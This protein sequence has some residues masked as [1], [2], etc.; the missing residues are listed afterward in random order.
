MRV[1]RLSS[2]K[3]ALLRGVSRSFYVSIRLLPQSLREPIA[4]AYLLARATDTIADTTELPAF[5]RRHIL[6][7]LAGAIETGTPAQAAV[8]TAGR[9]VALQRDPHERALIVALPTCIAWLR[10]LDAPDRDDIR[11]VL[12]LITQGQMLDVD[13]FADRSALHALD[14]ADQLREYAYLVAGSVGEFWTRVCGRHIPGFA[15]LPEDRMLDLARQY[16]AGLQLVNIARDVGADLRQGR[17]YF[18]LEE[19]QAVGLVPAAILGQPDQFAPVRDR[20]LQEAQ[21]GLAAGIAYCDAVRS[22]RLRAASALPAL[23]GART[24]ALMRA[25]GPPS[26]RLKVK[27]PRAEVRSVMARLSFSLAGREAIKALFERLGR[28]ALAAGWDNPRP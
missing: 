17:C 9:F 5:E 20:W 11:Q 4:L 16:G 2:D 1:A 12:R 8:A 22:R 3:L 15:T 6:Q 14:S 28:G 19:L 27:V 21:Q 13:R 7:A 25:A 10:E 18:P 23:L 26:L 24:I